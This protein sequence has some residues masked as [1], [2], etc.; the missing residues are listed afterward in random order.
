MIHNA[1]AATNKKL[2]DNI[3]SDCKKYDRGAYAA[4]QEVAIA[5]CPSHRERCCA[6]ASAS[7]AYQAESISPL[8]RMPSS[9]ASDA[10]ARV[11]AH[12]KETGLN[13]CIYNCPPKQNKRCCTQK[14]NIMCDV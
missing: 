14:K 6:G 3:H 1:S 10:N 11:F 7:A 2:T 4:L 13:A 12:A 8:E 9:S 5:R